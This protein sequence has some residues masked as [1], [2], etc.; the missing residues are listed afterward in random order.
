MIE[1]P[2]YGILKP[3]YKSWGIKES[4]KGV[5]FEPLATR[6]CTKAELHIHNETD[7]KSKFYKPHVNSV[8]DLS[9][10]YRK[11]K[12]MDADKIEV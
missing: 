7:P 4:V 11:L 9:F 2:T 3:Y 10:Y 5:D 12:C 8:S 6:E 1:D